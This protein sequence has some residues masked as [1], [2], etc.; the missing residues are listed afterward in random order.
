MTPR[1]FRIAASATAPRSSRPV[2]ARRPLF[3]RRRQPLSGFA[4]NCDAPTPGRHRPRLADRARPLL[5]TVQHPYPDDR[6][7]CRPF[8]QIGVL[9]LLVTILARPSR[10]HR[11]RARSSL[12]TGARS[13]A[14]ADAAGFPAPPTGRPSRAQRRAAAGVVLL[15]L[16]SGGTATILI[17]ACGS[18]AAW[19]ISWPCPA[20]SSRPNSASPRS[21]A[22]SRWSTA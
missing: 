19:A 14:A 10:R 7:G 13:A 2:A 22:A 16:V 8:A 18:G 17:A 20:L 21:A 9:A 11:R 3:R 4:P 12:A 1:R 15:L 5:A 6:A